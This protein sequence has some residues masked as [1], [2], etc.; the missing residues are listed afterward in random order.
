MDSGGKPLAMC[1]RLIKMT[2]EEKTNKGVPKTPT[3][4]KTAPKI[5]EKSTLKTNEKPTLRS[6]DKTNDSS[7]KTNDKSNASKPDA[8]ADVKVKPNT[9]TDLLK[10]NGLKPVTPN[11][12]SLPVKQP[13]PDP[14]NP[15]GV[16][17][18][19]APVKKPLEFAL[20]SDEELGEEEEEEEEDDEEEVTDDSEYES[21]EEVDFGKKNNQQVRSTFRPPWV[22][23]ETSNKV[24][25]PWKLNRRVRELP[26]KEEVKEEVPAFQ[27]E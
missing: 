19:P 15:F 4:E 20:S 7:L 11:S 17:L 1:D 25:V 9:A 27:S 22:K 24:D 13:E 5:N 10:G 16:K 2:D 18:R 8:K 14:V 6:N 21:E 12:K 23:D 26:K 3:N